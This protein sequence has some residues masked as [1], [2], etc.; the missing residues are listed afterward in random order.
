MIMLNNEL[1][2]PLPNEVN[3][4]RLRDIISFRFTDAQL[5]DLNLSFESYRNNSKFE[6]T[7][8][9]FGR[10]YLLE[11]ILKELNNYRLVDNYQDNPKHEYD[12]LMAYLL[13]VDEVNAT[14][15][16]LL[17]EAEKH[18]GDS[19]L[20][21]RMLWT[22]SISQ[23]EYN[24]DASAAFE[25]Y[26]M[27]AFS[28]YALIEHK[29]YLKEYLNY[30]GF[31]SIS[32]YLGSIKQVTN[33][34][35]GYQK[36]DVFKKLTYIRPIPGINPAHLKNWSINSLIGKKLITIDEIRK[37]PLFE[38]EHGDFMAIDEAIY[39]KKPYKGPLFELYY[40][41]ALRNSMSFETYSSRIAMEVME[42][43]VFQSIM[44]VLSKRKSDILWF[45]DTTDNIPDCYYRHNKDILLVEFKGYLFPATL[46]ANPNFDAIKKYIDNRFIENE[47]GNPKGISQIINQ[48]RL[49]SQKY[50]NFDP[51]FNN[52]IISNKAA[53]YPIIVHTEF[54]FT[55]PGINEYLNDIYISKVA[56][57][58]TQVF[59]LKPVTAIGLDTLFDYAV[60]GGTM[61]SLIQLLDRYQ[62][63]LANRKTFYNKNGG[64]DNYLRAKSS[65]D[66]I[67]NSIFFSEMQKSAISSKS[68]M[69]MLQITQ[70][71]IDTHL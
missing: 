33:A 44:K 17:E 62:N 26:R 39:R 18:K 7:N 9:V 29:A 31:E 41:T 49:L 8:D 70:T 25:I 48:I 60:R 64:T 10:R 30:L 52:K 40:S 19:L 69:G 57:A 1:N 15:Q 58:I 50:F 2:A 37:R 13:V 32:Q 16:L 4:R 59:R 23:Y 47:Q 65:F 24:E 35:L 54:H 43:S 14:D 5:K 42:K 63:I 38:T 20:N 21:Y 27:L 46:S 56:P 53:I 22:P 28:K 51:V 71:D 12:L 36:D 67:Y 61:Q 3:Q 6:Y 66:E 11:V 34:T 55:M 45:D 68:L